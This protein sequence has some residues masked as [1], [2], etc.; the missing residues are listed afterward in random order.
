MAGFK[1]NG[2]EGFDL[3]QEDQQEGKK[4]SASSQKTDSKKQ[5]P[6][7]KKKKLSKDDENK[8]TL[9]LDEYALGGFKYK[10]PG[11]RQ[12]I[13]VASVVLGLNVALVIAVLLY[14]KNPGFH[15]F[16]Y[17]VGRDV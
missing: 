11:K 10:L 16:I 5:V 13:I 17:N 3:N 2:P 12:R 14:L 4:E 9:N 7:A 8:K 1:Q 15:D 6:K